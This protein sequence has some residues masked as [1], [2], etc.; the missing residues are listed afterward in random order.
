MNKYLQ[1]LNNL[2]LLHQRYQIW[3]LLDGR[4]STY[5]LV[6][7]LESWFEALNWHFTHYII[8]HL[9]PLYNWFLQRMSSYTVQSC[10]ESFQ[11]P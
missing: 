6:T 3:L 4:E 11:V 10:M 8:I 9:V 1:N 2:Y 5:W 7:M